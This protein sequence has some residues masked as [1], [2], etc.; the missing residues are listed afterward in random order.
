[1]ELGGLLTATERRS[2]A[3]RRVRRGTYAAPSPCPRDVATTT[4]SPQFPAPA[5]AAGEDG[6]LSL[7]LP[8]PTPDAAD[9]RK[10]EAMLK[11]G[12]EQNASDVH[13]HAYGPLKHRIAGQLQVTEESVDGEFVEW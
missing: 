8:I 4:T 9:R 12:V 3:A 7:E 2:F 13:F 11:L 5:S 1:M 6:T 10:L